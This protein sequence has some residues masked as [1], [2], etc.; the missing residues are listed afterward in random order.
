MKVEQNK[1]ISVSYELRIN[2][3]EGE[4]ADLAYEESPLNFIYGIGLMLPKF[5]ANLKDLKAGDNFEFMLTHEEGYGSRNEDYLSDV[6]KHLFE[7][8]GKIESGLLEIGNFIPMQDD[9]GNHFVGKVVSV[10]DEVVRLDFNHPLAGE[11]LF[12]SGK[13]VGIREATQQEL[14][15]G[16]VHGHGHD[17]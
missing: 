3:K 14:E 12:F 7:Q 8:N 6:P 10:N 9:K 11:N 5:E 16:H 17:H 13:I 4:I 1:V 2:G 15:H